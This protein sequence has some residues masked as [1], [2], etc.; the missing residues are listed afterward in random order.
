MKVAFATHALRGYPPQTTSMPPTE[1]QHNL[2]HWAKQQGF[3]GIEVGNWWFDFCTVEIEQVVE[4]KRVMAEYGLELAGFNCLRK[5]VT[6]PAVRERNRADLR[7]TVEVAKVVRPH[8][9]SISLSLEPSVLS[10]N[11]ENIRGVQTSPG[12]GAAASESEYIDAAAFLAELAGDAAS[13]EVEVALELHHCSL[14]DTSKRVLHILELANHPNLSVNPD[15]VNLYWA[16]ERPEEQWYEAITNVAGYVNFWHV[17]N[18]QRIHIPEV[19]RSCSVHAALGDG[20]IDYRWALARLLEGG[21]DGYIS[22]E[23]AGPGD[24]LAFASRGKKY[25]DELLSDAS[26]G[27]GLAVH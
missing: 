10:V 17:K 21:F 18:V 27:V 22:I 15:V 8:V 4:L 3:D 23:G 12:G 6:H 26:S 2:F 1:M 19:G 11:E 9:V 25:L 13:A 7:R 24:L 16:Y 5:C 20:D 14:A